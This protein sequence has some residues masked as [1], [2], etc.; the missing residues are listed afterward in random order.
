MLLLTFIPAEISFIQLQ[1]KYLIS[2]EV[3]YCNDCNDGNENIT[4][5]ISIKCTLSKYNTV[6]VGR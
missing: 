3:R 4:D 6:V 1:M 2:F 5:F